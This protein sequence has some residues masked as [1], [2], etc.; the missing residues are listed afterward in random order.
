MHQVFAAHA[1]QRR[2]TSRLCSLGCVSITVPFCND[3]IDLYL[4]RLAALEAVMS[5]TA[6]TEGRVQPRSNQTP[7]GPG[8]ALQV[9]N[10]DENDTRE[11]RATSVTYSDFGQASPPSTDLGDRQ[12]LQWKATTRPDFMIGILDSNNDFPV[13]MMDQVTMP[14]YFS[15]NL[16]SDSNLMSSQASDFI[17]LCGMSSTVPNPCSRGSMASQASSWQFSSSLPVSPTLTPTGQENVQLSAL[18]KADLYVAWRLHFPL[19]SDL[20]R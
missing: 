14:D 8:P 9:E 12:S 6:H 4:V 16:A 7:T 11:A 10:D 15:Y 5:G 19:C 1:G 13:T 3:D 20:P 18:V 2:A 17:D